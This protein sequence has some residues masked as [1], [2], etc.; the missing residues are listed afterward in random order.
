M[1]TSFIR[2]CQR[3]KK[4][5]AEAALK[6]GRADLD[7]QDR[8]GNTAL[9]YLCTNDLA[10][11]AEKLIAAGAD[12]S[13]ANNAGQTP[14]HLAASNGLLSAVRLLLDKGAEINAQDMEDKTPLIYAVE[15]GKAD[16]AEYLLVSGA[17]RHS[18]T[19]NGLFPRDFVKAAGPSMERLQPFFEAK[20][21]QIDSKGNTPLHQAVYQGGITTVKNLLSAGTSSINYKNNKG[22]TPLLAAVS[23][24]NLA[25]SGIL[26]RHGAD[27]NI[28]RPSD[29]YSSL[30][31]AAENG[32]SLLGEILL[33]HAAKIDALSNDG[34]TPLILA[35][36]WQ[37]RDF[38][39]MLL[40]RGADPAIT[41]KEGKTAR[42]YAVESGF[43]S[44]EE[45]FLTKPANSRPGT[46]CP[47][48]P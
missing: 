12:V 48:K 11:L 15:N 21:T 6:S 33:D 39:A 22:L 40:R 37:H 38:A 29:G 10:D 19:V 36:Q 46:R 32:L 2:L 41:D 30:H 35:A 1:E 3:G 4:A 24:L 43:K 25:I 20:L 16:A 13:L 26:L 31:V 17:D 44:I 8:L 5:S 34:A 18:M 7:K 28:P 27:P 42:D 23:N 14:L 9:H 45:V 47:R